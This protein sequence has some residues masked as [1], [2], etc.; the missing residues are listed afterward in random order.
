MNEKSWYQTLKKPRWSPDSSIFGR[1]WTPLY[2]IITIVNVYVLTEVIIDKLSWN[3]GLAFWINLF[4]NLIFT[5]VQFGLK[6]NFLAMV[7]IYLI[8]LTVAW[9][10]FIIWPYSKF[11]S[12]A[13]LPYLIWVS[14]ATV[15]QTQIWLLNR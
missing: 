5:P 1:V 11:T 14:I 10:M 4:F 12:L 3:I 15:L 8:L 2:V 7:V 9:A 6:N 13:Y